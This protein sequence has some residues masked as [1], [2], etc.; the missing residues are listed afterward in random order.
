MKYVAFNKANVLVQKNAGYVHYI[1]ALDGSGSMC[2]S[3]WQQALT[4]S[5]NAIK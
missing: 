1:Y 3:A 2:G 5:K 4:A